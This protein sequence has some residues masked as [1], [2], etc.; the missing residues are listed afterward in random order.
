MMEPV[1]PALREDLELLEGPLGP[2]GRMSFLIRDGVLNRFIRISQDTARL[3]AEWKAGLSMGAFL[4]H[5]AERQMQLPPAQLIV[6]LR[7]LEQSQLI[8]QP[9]GK[10]LVSRRPR[11]WR[12]ILRSGLHNYLFF[13]IPL[14]Y[15]DHF[16]Q[17]HKQKFDFLFSRWFF[18][19]TLV[20]LVGDVVLMVPRI[21]HASAQLA[22]QATLVTA[23]K[24]IAA[25]I[26]SKIVHEFAHG[27]VAAR[28]GCMVSSFGVGFMLAFPIFYADVTDT[29]RIRDDRGRLAVASAGLMA[30]ITLAIYATALWI[31]N[32]VPALS[33]FFLHLALAIWISSLL[34]NA[35]PLMRFDGYHI[36]SD[37][38]GEK[39]LQA[40]SFAAMRVFLRFHLGFISNKPD[41]KRQLLIY[42]FAAAIYRVLLITGI[43]LVLFH[44][45]FRLLGIMLFIIE[46]W[47]FL[48]GPLVHELSAMKSLRGKTHDSAKL[49]R[50]SLWAG[51]FVLVLFVPFS[52]QISAPAIATYQRVIAIYTR[53]AGISQSD[54]AF[55]A[56]AVKADEPL[57]LLTHPD[58]VSRLEQ[59]QTVLSFLQ[60]RRATMAVAEP[61]RTRLQAIEAEIDLEQAK[62]QAIHDQLEQLSPHAT[63]S[64]IFWPRDEIHTG[65][66][67]AGRSLIGQIVIGG[68]RAVAFVSESELSAIELGAEA[69]FGDDFG[70]FSVRGRVNHIDLAASASLTYP[71]L[72]S[73]NGG[74]IEAR[75]AGRSNPV[76]IH[77][78][79]RVEIDLAEPLF[80]VRTLGSVRI[81]GTRRS[82]AERAFVWLV[83]LVRRESYLN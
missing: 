22:S 13:K 77:S 34:I 50:S 1:L 44:I 80:S 81:Y 72:A 55:T 71:E 51:A 25:Y 73:V 69:V 20:V 49:L 54:V 61:D 41:L 67:V 83:A 64:G 58:L 46:I 38:L 30:E 26:F 17:T 53:D 28:H 9:S 82:V 68:Q 62:S 2:D 37:F 6:F 47:L 39:N 66:W 15:P 76:S 57:V 29:W 40:R 10:P 60:A 4:N 36:L 19:V 70:R 12:S 7:F 11:G 3:L 43:A 74:T 79:Y 35:N 45:A 23:L 78:V 33:S 18:W 21:D 5:L 24:F 63:E 8:Q 27:L 65:Q 75:V 48:L 56:R 42:G 52:A 32:P 59:S 16:I 14:L 31:L